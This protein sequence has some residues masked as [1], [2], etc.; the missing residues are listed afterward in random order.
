VL[1]LVTEPED[2]GLAEVDVDGVEDITLVVLLLLSP[3]VSIVELPLSDEELVLLLLVIKVVGELV[4][5]P[6][7]EVAGVSEGEVVG[8]TEDDGIDVAGLLPEEED[9]LVPALVLE[10]TEVEGV[11]VIIGKVGKVPMEDE[12][13]HRS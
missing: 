1:P 13:Q 3:P 9:E 11:L 2:E 12:L 5:V 8:V 10:G 7:G 6:E 4:G